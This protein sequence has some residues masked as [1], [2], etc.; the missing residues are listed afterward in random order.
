MNPIQKKG[1][2]QTIQ[3]SISILLVSVNTIYSYIS[4]LGTDRIL[5]QGIRFVLTV[6]LLVVLYKG[7]KWARVVALFLFGIAIFRA[8]G[9]LFILEAD[10]L[11]KVPV[12]VM[13]VVYSVAIYH[14]GASDY[15]MA[16]AR[17]QNGVK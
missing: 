14:F 1:Q 3:V 17:Y 16:F 7:K 2:K 13:I 10:L 9:G 12:I 15:Y 4:K 5:E 11:A 8:I 6:A